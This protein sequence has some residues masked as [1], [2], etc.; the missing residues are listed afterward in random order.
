M[1]ELIGL[2]SLGH[3]TYYAGGLSEGPVPC[4]LQAKGSGSFAE[5]WLVSEHQKFRI[6]FSMKMTGG[7]NSGRVRDINHCSQR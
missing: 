6:C 5:Y 3:F 1:S 4:F 2:C 7:W